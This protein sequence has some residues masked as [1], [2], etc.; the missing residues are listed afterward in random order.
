MRCS[1]PANLA[2][3]GAC[4]DILSARGR[5]R[6]TLVRK[7][8]RLPVAHIMHSLSNLPCLSCV[9]GGA[10]TVDWSLFMP[11]NEMSFVIGGASEVSRFLCQ[12]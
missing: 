1:E 2:C 9:E 12:S 11:I 8:L 10:N 3:L 4:A 5:E 6:P 7:R